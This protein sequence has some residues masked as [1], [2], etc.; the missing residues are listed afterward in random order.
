ME[1]G[2]C[3]ITLYIFYPCL[4]WVI[5]CNFIKFWLHKSTDKKRKK[6]HNEG[7]EDGYNV[8]ISAKRKTYSNNSLELYV[9]GSIVI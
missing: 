5:F 9:L 4:T 6:I 1:S 7:L 3:G 2:K 8:V